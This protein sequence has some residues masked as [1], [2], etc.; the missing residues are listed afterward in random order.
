MTACLG[1]FSSP[2]KE[3]LY[4]S[5]IRSMTS[6]PPPPPPPPPGDLLLCLGICLFCT[7]HI[8]GIT[9]S[10]LLRLVSSTEHPMCLFLCHHP[11]PI[12]PLAPRCQQSEGQPLV[13]YRALFKLAPTSLSFHLC[14]TQPAPRHSRAWKYPLPSPSSL[15]LL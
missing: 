12:A 6:A 7:V 1:T 13:S 9:Q 11:A 15:F 14:T 5:A 8:S 4:P 10:G 3:T 2:Q